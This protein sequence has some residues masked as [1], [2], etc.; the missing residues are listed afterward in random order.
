MASGAARQVGA[1]KR[2]APYLHEPA[3]R[4]N[5][6]PAL[7]G[8]ST[9]LQPSTQPSALLALLSGPSR[10]PPAGPSTTRSLLTT[11][12][13]STQPSILRS[14]LAPPPRVAASPF[15]ALRLPSGA[16]PS[17]KQ[18]KSFCLSKSLIYRSKSRL[19]FFP[20]L[21][22]CKLNLFLVC[23]AALKT[24]TALNGATTRT[25]LPSTDACEDINNFFAAQ[26]DNIRDV[27][28]QAVSRDV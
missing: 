20:I 27:I 26:E 7:G 3:K 21:F 25:T 6:A 19:S 23:I 9:Y 1:L 17:P 2:P 10:L 15:S 5:M 12:P 24:K 18:R 16:R 14:M 22:H 8:P 28:G 11:P 13:P 4:A